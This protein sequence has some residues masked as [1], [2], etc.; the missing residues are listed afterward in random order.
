MT[1]NKQKIDYIDR[2]NI[3]IFANDAYKF[4]NTAFI[5]LVFSNIY[6]IPI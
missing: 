4:I 1:I 5:I 6:T 2:E 3:K